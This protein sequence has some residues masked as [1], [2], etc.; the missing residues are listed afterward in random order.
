MYGGLEKLGGKG[1][2]SAGAVLWSPLGGTLVG[3]AGSS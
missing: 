2:C 3:V 1:G